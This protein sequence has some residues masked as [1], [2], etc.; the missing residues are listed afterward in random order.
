[1]VRRGMQAQLTDHFILDGGHETEEPFRRLGEALAP[2]L[3]GRE[4]QLQRTPYGFGTCKNTLHGLVIARFGAADRD[5]HEGSLPS[6]RIV[7][8]DARGCLQ[9]LILQSVDLADVK[10]VVGQPVDQEHP[11]GQGTDLGVLTG[12]LPGRILEVFEPENGG[13]PLLE[14]VVQLCCKVLL[15]I[16]AAL[17]PGLRVGEWQGPRRIFE[18]GA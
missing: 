10:V 16:L 17:D 7:E 15:Q 13:L 12:V 9:I 4:R 1:M 6:S 18:H 14:E 2:L 8:T 5:R 11:G 3:R